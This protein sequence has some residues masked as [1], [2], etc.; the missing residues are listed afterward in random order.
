MVTGA[1]LSFEVGVYAQVLVLAPPPSP[2][3]SAHHLDK[4]V[5]RRT[6]GGTLSRKFSPLKEIKNLNALFVYLAP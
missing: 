3:C 5:A 2:K 6:G 1:T 4:P